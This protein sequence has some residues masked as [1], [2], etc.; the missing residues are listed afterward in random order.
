MKTF[1]LL[2]LI[3]IASYSQVSPDSVYVIQH[4]TKELI[5]KAYKKEELLRKLDS[6]SK[7]RELGDVKLINF[8]PNGV[9]G[10]YILRK[11]RNGNI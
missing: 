9:R 6:T 4:E 3:S 8:Y 7:K 10:S 1:I 2:L 5:I 11:R